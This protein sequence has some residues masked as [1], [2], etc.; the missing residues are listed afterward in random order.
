MKNAENTPGRQFAERPPTP[1]CDAFRPMTPE[2]IK[3]KNNKLL[4][5][6]ENIDASSKEAPI[7]GAKDT[8]WDAKPSDTNKQ[9]RSKQESA[10]GAP[11]K[12]RPTAEPGKGYLP[13]RRESRDSPAK[14][15]ASP[16]T[17]AMA[18]AAKKIFGAGKHKRGGGSEQL[19]PAG[20]KRSLGSLLARVAPVGPKKS[21]TCTA[22]GTTTQQETAA[23]QF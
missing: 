14:S 15:P 12:F 21:A 8:F 4:S 13:R 11:A 1:M 5:S 20:R 22:I 18:N 16:T 7:K 6:A 2:E 3:M 19:P 23:T 10:A 17:T 9:E